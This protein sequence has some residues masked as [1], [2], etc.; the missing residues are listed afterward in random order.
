M[1]PTCEGININELT[2]CCMSVINAKH[3]GNKI[4]RRHFKIFLLLFCRKQ[5][6]TFH[7]NCLQMC[8][9]VRDNLHERSSLFSGEN[10]NT[11]IELSFAELTNRGVKIK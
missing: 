6:L 4:S 7:A 5:A 10:R 9:K 1:R 3:A 2:E 8:R 11:I